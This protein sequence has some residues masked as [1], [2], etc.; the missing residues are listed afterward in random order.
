MVDFKYEFSCGAILYNKIE[1]S[2]NYRY[3]IVKDRNGNYSFPKGHMEDGE[4]EIETAYREVKEECNIDFVADK[5]F[6]YPIEY[7]SNENTIKIVKLFSGSFRILQYKIN[8]PEIKE[9]KIC[10]YADA[11]RLITYKEYKDALKEVNDR[12]ISKM[13]ICCM[14]DEEDPY[15]A[16]SNKKLELVKNYGSKCGNN[17]LYVW[18]EGERYLTKCKKCGSYVLVQD[19][20]MHMPDHVYIDYFPVRDENHA[21]E[22]NKNFGGYELEMKYPYKKLF[23]TDG[24]TTW[25]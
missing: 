7:K 12:L 10:N 18:D 21:M 25:H 6:L 9:I 5:N 17:Y 3:L 23:V 2:N 1:E 8:D 14:F 20:E 22:L 4:T 11:Y 16:Y 19:S 13:K 15:E 24:K